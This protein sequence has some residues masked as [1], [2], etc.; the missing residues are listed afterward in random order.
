VL[1]ILADEIIIV[2]ICRP[3]AEG[4]NRNLGIFDLRGT[5]SLYAR[6]SAP[7]ARHECTP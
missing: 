2:G 3:C 7:F 6:G 5:G 1:P 4:V